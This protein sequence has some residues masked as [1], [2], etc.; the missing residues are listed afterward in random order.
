VKIIFLEKCECDLFDYIENRGLL[1]LKE[2]KTK[3]KPILEA[4]R[5]IHLR[6][7]AHCDIKT[8]NI[9]VMKNGD[10]KLLDFGSCSSI[11]NPISIHL[12]SFLYFPPEI[13]VESRNLQKG[14]IWSLGITLYSCVT[15]QFPFYGDDNEYIKQVVNG[16]PNFDIIE[17]YEDYKDFISLLRGM[18]SKSSS[19]RFSIDDCLSHSFFF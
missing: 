12:G 9:G 11:E 2:I 13:Q 15:G 10:F 4:I 18:L 17:P 19:Q 8:E 7:A 3:M 1:S 6:N 14:D 16:E 5:L